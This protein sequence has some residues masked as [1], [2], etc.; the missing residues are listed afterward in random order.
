MAKSAAQ[1]V[2]AAVVAKKLLGKTVKL[3]LYTGTA[4]AV[5]KVLRGSD[6]G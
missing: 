1:K 4:A 5:A 2:G 3:V 6:E